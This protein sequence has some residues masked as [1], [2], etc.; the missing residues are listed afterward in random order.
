MRDRR[1]L[2]LARSKEGEPGPPG[3][4][5]TYSE[6]GQVH[7]LGHSWS[8]SEYGA[9]EKFRFHSAH[10]NPT[11][12]EEVDEH[13]KEFPGKQ[14]WPP[15]QAEKFYQNALKEVETPLDK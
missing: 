15:A 11:P 2:R 4:G 13:M 7:L 5:A 6:L 3:I 14:K 9:P 8:F 12:K 1:C 10:C